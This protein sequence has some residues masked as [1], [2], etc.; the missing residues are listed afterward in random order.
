MNLHSFTWSPYLNH[1]WDEEYRSKVEMKRLQ[2]AGTSHQHR[3][4]SGRNAVARGENLTLTAP[5][6]RRATSRSTGALPKRWLTRP[7][8]MKA[9]PIRIS[10]EDAGRGTFFHRHAVVHNQKNGSVYVPLAN[11][12]GGQGEFKVWDSGAAEEAV[13]AFE[14]GYATANR[15]R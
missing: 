9:S 4:G 5:R 15:A 11:I 6:W 8:R 1:E 14:Y 10:G 13:L 3:A 2:R 7:W 12:H